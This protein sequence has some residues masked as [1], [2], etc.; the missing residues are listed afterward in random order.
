MQNNVKTAK[1]GK[2][3]KE[4][5]EF[6]S[7][8]DLLKSEI[9]QLV[10]NPDD[11]PVLAISD[12]N[13]LLK[14]VKENKVFKLNHEN[15]WVELLIDLPCDADEIRESCEYLLED[16]TEFALPCIDVKSYQRHRRLL[17]ALGYY[18]ANLLTRVD[19]RK[20]A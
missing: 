20:H 17:R 1:I 5:R 14:I 6:K 16:L 4:D 15:A 11:D 3:S 18:F 13:S 7:Q 19:A 10:N 12:D 9:N 8:M 2:T